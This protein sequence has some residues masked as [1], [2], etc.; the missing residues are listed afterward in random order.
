MNT[1][2]NVTSEKTIDKKFSHASYE[3]QKNGDYLPN[4]DAAKYKEFLPGIA[5]NRRSGP[6][7]RDVAKML[8]LV[9]MLEHTASENDLVC[10]DAKYG[11]DFRFDCIINEPFWEGMTYE[12]FLYFAGVYLV[13]FIY[14][15]RFNAPSV[16]NIYEHCFYKFLGSMSGLADTVAK[17]KYKEIHDIIQKGVWSYDKDEDGNISNMPYETGKIKEVLCEMQ[18]ALVWDTDVDFFCNHWTNIPHVADCMPN[19]IQM[20]Q[21]KKSIEICCGFS[22]IDCVEMLN[23]LFE[24]KVK[25]ADKRETKIRSF[26]MKKK[27]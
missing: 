6:C 25:E 2:E 22:S 26:R 3:V 12:E 18:E 20:L 17:Q 24:K 9:W 21:V 7:D 19:R 23:N 8:A 1:T 13:D 15:H 5:V 11:M 4:F 27:F 16:A 10:D 14:H